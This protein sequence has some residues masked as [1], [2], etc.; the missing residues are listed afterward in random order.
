M[1]I[2]RNGR[3]KTIAAACL[4]VA[5]GT[6]TAFAH[7]DAT[8]IVKERMDAMDSM[9][10]AVKAL[11]EMFRGGTPFDAAEVSRQAAAIAVHGG[12][13]MTRLF[14]EHSISGP[15]EARPEIW[16][17][18]DRFSALAGQLSDFAGALAKAADNPRPQGGMMGGQGMMGQSGPTPEMLAA[19]PPDAA[20]MHLVETCSACHQDFR[21]AK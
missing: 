4:A 14:P 7:G 17:D 5:I 15:S 2:S 10:K 6:G 20:F 9:G 16:T 13:A 21:K 1:T 3:R 19:M 8:G 12:E 11:S 18:W